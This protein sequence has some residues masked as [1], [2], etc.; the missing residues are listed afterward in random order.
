MYLEMEG[1]QGNCVEA[2]ARYGISVLVENI[3]LASAGPFVVD[4]SNTREQVDEGLAAGQHIQL[5]FTGTTPSGRYEASAD[6]MNQIVEREEN[7]NTLTFLA[8][9]PTPPLACTSTPTPTP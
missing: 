4:L 5:H 1:S 2:Y 7:N 3:G 8:P 6:S 9:T